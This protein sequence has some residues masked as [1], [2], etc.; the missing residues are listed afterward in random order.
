MFYPINFFV[1]AD[2]FLLIHLQ[3]VISQRFFA[4]LT[5]LRFVL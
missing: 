5:Y 4:A 3:S 1:F 2:I